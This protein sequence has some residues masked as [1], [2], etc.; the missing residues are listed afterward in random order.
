MARAI[1][2]SRVTL[3]HGIK[4]ASL[5]LD[6]KDAAPVILH[7]LDPTLDTI[8]GKEFINSAVDLFYCRNDIDFPSDQFIIES[9]SKRQFSF[10]IAV[11]I[12]SER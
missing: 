2:G 4:S 5:S 7:K 6:R 1:H 12:R 9:V 10:L 11:L 3:E 8:P